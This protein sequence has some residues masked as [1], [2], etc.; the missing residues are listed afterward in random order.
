MEINKT[1]AQIAVEKHELEM[2][3]RFAAIGLMTRYSGSLS[4]ECLLAKAVEEGVRIGSQQLV[5]AKADTN[6]HVCEASADIRG[7]CMVC[8]ADTNK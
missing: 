6:N 4:L 3:Y 2:R 1:A 8:G 7:W 5:N